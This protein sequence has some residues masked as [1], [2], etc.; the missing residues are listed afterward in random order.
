MARQVQRRRRGNSLFWVL[1]LVLIIAG[2][3]YYSNSDI[4]IGR[5]V[6][7]PTKPVLVAIGDT[8][9]AIGVVAATNAVQQFEAT[10]GKRSTETRI[11]SE[12]APKDLTKWKI[13]MLV[14]APGTV[15]TKDVRVYTSVHDRAKAKYIQAATAA[16]NAMRPTY[17]QT[18][19]HSE[20]NLNNIGQLY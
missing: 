10:L 13:V 9:N 20:M 14:N 5:A 7:K 18:K 16:L 8:S 6:A 3:W 19:L 1:L 4:G 12:V 2:Y 15:T 17:S 11:F